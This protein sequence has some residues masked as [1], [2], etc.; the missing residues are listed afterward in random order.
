MAIKEVEEKKDDNESLNLRHGNISLVLHSY[1]GIFSDFDPRTY[2]ERGISDD[3]LTEV[4]RAV[5]ETKGVT[6]LR[7]LMP[8][9]LRKSHE[10]IKI[11]KRLKDY[12]RKRFKD[13]EEKIKKIKKEGIKWFFIGSLILVI[14]TLLY[15]Y[16]GRV[17][18]SSFRLLLDFLF[19]ISQ[20]A[21]WFTFWEGLGKV[22]IVSREELPVYDFY[23]KM[24]NANIYFLNY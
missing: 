11:K 16:K 14:S 12:F 6:E 7:L 22:F 19:I 5:R 15:E 20:P 10:E 17:D 24:S 21:G 9:Q 13:E 8:A 18:S 4:K 2:E 3:F 1:S 23:K